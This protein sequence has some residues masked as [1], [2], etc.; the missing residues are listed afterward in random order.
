MDLQ[1]EDIKKYQKY[2]KFYIQRRNIKF[3]VHYISFDFLMF[4]FKSWSVQAM[5]EVTSQSLVI[6]TL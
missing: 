6:F 1:L 3:S 4:S 5:H 2:Q